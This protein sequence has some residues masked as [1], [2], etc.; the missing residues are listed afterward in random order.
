MDS[1]QLGDALDQLR[2]LVAELRP[3]L[4]DLRFGVLDDVVKKRG[5]DRLLVLAQLRENHRGAPGMAD[6]RLTGAALLSLVAC[7]A[8]RNARASNSRSTSGL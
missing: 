1:R 6:E 7:A 5:G 4:I 3:H 8:K 2:D